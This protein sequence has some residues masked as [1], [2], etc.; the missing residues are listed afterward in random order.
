ML[1]TY[2][3]RINIPY[4]EEMTR[5]LQTTVH[6]FNEQPQLGSPT[7]LQYHTIL[8]DSGVVQQGATTSFRLFTK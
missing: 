4:S 6:K 7:D 5:K 2:L 1:S 8:E 3:S